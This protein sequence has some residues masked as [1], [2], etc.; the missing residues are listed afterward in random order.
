[1]PDS[2]ARPEWRRRNA[3]LLRLAAL[4]VFI[5]GSVLCIGSFERTAGGANIIW[6]ANGMELAFLLLVPRWHWPRYMVVSFVAM[7]LGSIL[8]GETVGMSLLYNCLNCVEVLIGALLL[9]RRAVVLLR[10][11]LLRQFRPPG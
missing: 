9:K 10:C 4:F 3:A 1:M 7:V 11:T 8:I 6:L 2:A 5:T